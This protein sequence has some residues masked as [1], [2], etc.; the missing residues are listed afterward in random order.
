M[1]ELLCCCADAFLCR[2][3]PR[4]CWF[5]LGWSGGK[6]RRVPRN[7]NLLRAGKN[8]NSLTAFL[9][10]TDAPEPWEGRWAGVTDGAERWHWGKLNACGI[11]KV[12]KNS[13]EGMSEPVVSFPPSWE[14]G[15]KPSG[16]GSWRLY[17]CWRSEERT[18]K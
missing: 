10:G 18:G 9:V 8:A 1:L 13:A 16:S 14:L 17:L 12:W 5:N 4:Q 3:C 11:L 7:L 2:H 15:K 6:R